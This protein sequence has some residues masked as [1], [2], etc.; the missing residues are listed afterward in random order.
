M[1]HIPTTTLRTVGLLLVVAFEAASDGLRNAVERIQP[2]LRP[3]ADLRVHSTLGHSYTGIVVIDDNDVL[4]GIVARTSRSAEAARP[5]A[6]SPSLPRHRPA[7]SL[8]GDD[9]SVSDF[10]DLDDDDEGKLPGWAAD[11]RDGGRRRW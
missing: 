1:D 10:D 11:P 8:F 6:H 5:T 7:R 4:G 9:D 2:Y 3:P